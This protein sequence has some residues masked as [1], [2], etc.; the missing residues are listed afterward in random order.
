LNY[1]YLHYQIGLSQLY[2]IGPIKAKELIYKLESAEQLFSA[3]QSEIQKLTGL[4]IRAIQKMDRKK[5]LEKSI[6]VINHLQKHSIDTS[7]YTSDEYPRRLKQ[8]V[9][10]PILLYKKG[11]CLVNSPKLVAIVGTRNATHY[12]QSI[13]R[14]LIASFQGKNIVVVSG[15]ALGIDSYVH[16][17]CLD[18][19]V[20]TIGVMGHGFDR[21]YP[22]KNRTLA[23]E[24]LVDGAL[25]TEF[26]PGTDPDREN[27]PKRNRIVAGMT[28]ATIVVESNIK[29]GSLITA[30]L[31]NDYNRDVFAFP[32]NINTKTSQGCNQLIADQKAHL[33]QSPG[34]FL[35]LMG[36]NE[37][38]TVETVQKA[39]FLDLSIHQQQ[40]VAALDQ[41]TQLPIDVLSL[42]AKLPITELNQELFHLEMEGLIRSLPG[43]S[44]V[45]T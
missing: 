35:A 27:F 42:K 10:A 12:G 3:N 30:R 9:D 24:M 23:K 11:N 17:Y 29:G 39:L 33:I 18:F 25:L 41:E 45:L 40:I 15:L 26:I 7:F 4:N 44:Y 20:P 37:D 34:D 1:T 21:I 32:G 8:C 22:A 13:V 43:K 31:A 36:W 19:G 6:A 28:D 16:K 14:D 2:G 38:N 5:A